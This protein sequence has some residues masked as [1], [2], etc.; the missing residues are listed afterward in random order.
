VLEDTAGKPRHIGMSRTKKL[1]ILFVLLA[2]LGAVAA[3][4]SSDPE[5]R[6][7]SRKNCTITLIDYCA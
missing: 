4:M 2:L 1:A 3:A 5:W 6:Y 7:L